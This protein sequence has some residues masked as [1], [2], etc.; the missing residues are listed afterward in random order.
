MSKYTLKKLITS[1]LTDQGFS[2]SIDGKIFLKERS[3]EINRKVHLLAKAER[4]AK[5]QEFIRKFSTI[6]GTNIPNGAD[7]CV[8]KIQPILIEVT[9][10]S[11]AEEYFRWWNLI[12]WSL[13]YE[14]AYGRQ[15][16]YI[17]WDDYH[18]AVI[19][20]IGLQSPI[21][22]WSVRDKYL[23]ISHDKRDTIVNQSLS[24]QRAGAVPPYN[25]LLGGKLVA[26]LMTCDQ[27]RK[28]F[29]RKYSNV[30]TIIKKREIPARLLFLT[31]TGAYG[32]SSIYQRLK[33]QGDALAR[34]IGYSQGS[35]SFHIPNSL[36]EM[37]LE[38][39]K[40]N[41]Y[42]I[43][44]GYGAGPSR[45]LRLID[46]ALSRLGFQNGVEHGIL[47]AVYLFPLAKNLENVIQKDKRPIWYKRNIGELTDFWKERWA[48]PRASRNSSYKA[49]KVGEFM[50]SVANEIDILCSFSGGNE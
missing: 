5:R 9:P 10:N 36:Y 31:T 41:N 34:F 33:Y 24:A 14:R 43:T 37:L 45:K 40:H 11:I 4:I 27:V 12:W 20:L 21:L 30:E 7:I 28:D 49:F 25:Y 1:S 13:P 26:M 18:R 32:K 2:I 19:G 48:L 16:R 29:K 50:D 38:Y 42:D 22:S 17:I 44:R 15:I 3:R 6:A 23:N 39:L 46:T 35:G 8:D 47:R